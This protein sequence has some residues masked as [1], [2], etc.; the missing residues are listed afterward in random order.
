M[1]ENDVCPAMI[2][3]LDG[4]DVKY[5]SLLPLRIGYANDMASP[6]AVIFISVLPGTLSRELGIVHAVHCR[7]I[8]VEH[9]IEDMHVEIR[10][11]TVTRAASLFKPAISSNPAAHLIEPFS[12]SL[13]IPISL[14]KTPFVEGT[15]SFFFIDPSKPGQ[16]FL[17]TARHVVINPNDHNNLYRFRKGSGQPKIQVILLGTAAFLAR[18]KEIQAAI[19]GQDLVVQQLDKRLADADQ[20]E[21]EDDAEEERAAV[22]RLKEDAARAK[23]I[24]TKLLADVQRDW[25]EPA[26][27]TIGH[28]IYSPPISFNSQDAFTEDWAVIQIDP[29]MINNSNFKGNAIDVGSIDVTTLTAYMYPNPKSAHSFEYPGNRLHKCYGM[30]SDQEMFSPHPSTLDQDEDA[31]LMVLKNGN[32]T[33][34]TVGRLDT[35][36]A[37]VRTYFKGKPGFL[38]REIAVL[39]RTSKSGAF[40]ARGDSGALVV[41]AKGRLCCMLTGGDGVSVNTDITY[42][43]SANYILQQLRACG[44]QANLFPTKEEL[45]NLLTA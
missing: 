26:N 35:I 17:V 15:G 37:F 38:S 9:G 7:N 33:G 27:R 5:G 44:F 21:D 1:W 19:D 22:A 20:L 43:T 2:R 3:Y 16:L 32:T 42:G 13:G 4:K 31:T 12:T 40:S 30:V 36:C 6:P 8:L 10:E 24:Q 11:S 39:P 25:K 41:D 29:K 45:A 14:L 28:V 18:L 34:L 23:A